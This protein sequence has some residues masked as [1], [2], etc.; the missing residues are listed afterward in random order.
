[1]KKLK[2]WYLSIV[3][4]FVNAALFASTAIAP[5]ETK[6]F[7]QSVIDFL[8]QNW[9]WLLPGLTWLLHRIIPTEKADRIITII[10]WI[11]DKLIPDRKKQGG[12]H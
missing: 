8:V 3:L 5:V 10:K 12:K 4:L 6:T 1:M 2:R 7:L 11:F 9:V